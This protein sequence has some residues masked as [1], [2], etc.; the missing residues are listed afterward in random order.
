M[1]PSLR[2]SSWPHSIKH[3]NDEPGASHLHRVVAHPT[4]RQRAIAPSLAELQSLPRSRHRRAAA[5]RSPSL[6]GV[7]FARLRYRSDPFVRPSASSALPSDPAAGVIGASPLPAVQP[8][9]GVHVARHQLPLHRHRAAGPISAAANLRAGR[10]PPSHCRS[11]TAA[12]TAGR[13]CRP[14]PRRRHAVRSARRP[15]PPEL[16]PPP[17]GPPSLSPLFPSLPHDLS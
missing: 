1:K 15:R 13:C 8:L 16:Q 14:P 17:G 7:A 6:A 12:S 11:A 2:Y 10:P 4:G 3:K 5:H 9:A